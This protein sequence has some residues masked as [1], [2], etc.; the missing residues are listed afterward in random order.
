MT[1]KRKVIVSIASPYLS[2][3][4]VADRGLEHA[5]KYGGLNT[6]M[7]G[8]EKLETDK[9]EV[10]IETPD[11]P[12]TRGPTESDLMIIGSTVPAENDVL[13]W[14]GTG[15]V[16]AR[17][18][19]FYGGRSDYTGRH[20][21]MGGYS[22]DFPKDAKVVKELLTTDS[23]LEGLVSRE[24]GKIRKAVDEFSTDREKPVLVTPYL[25]VALTGVAE[26]EESL[27][28]ALREEDP[29]DFGLKAYATIDVMKNYVTIGEAREVLMRLHAHGTKLLGSESD[30]DVL[31][32]FRDMARSI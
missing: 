21:A 32:G 28:L 13:S 19:T 26:Y 8:V 1:G 27:S 14:K 23:F 31:Y 7:I 9:H 29:G 15:L 16:V 25:S 18:S 30:V 12:I 24:T 3:D 2:R 4:V 17:F 22:L 11:K 20:P 6:D 5:K 10:L